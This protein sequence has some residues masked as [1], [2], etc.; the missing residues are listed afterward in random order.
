M[1]LPCSKETKKKTNK[2]LKCET[3][4]NELFAAGKI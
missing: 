2:I 3:I 1:T 4:F